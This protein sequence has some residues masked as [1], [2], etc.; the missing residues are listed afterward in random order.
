MTRIK[1]SD[2]MCLLM[3]K[4][5]TCGLSLGGISPL[6]RTLSFLILVAVMTVPV[7]AFAGAARY[8]TPMWSMGNF[9]PHDPTNITA[10][11][12]SPRL[13]FK[14]MSLAELSAKID[15]GYT[16][17]AEMIGSFMGPSLRGKLASFYNRRNYPASG[18]P[19][20][21]FGDFC[22]FDNTSPGYLKAVCVEFTGGEDG[23]YV[24][25]LQSLY[26]ET[27]TIDQQNT[28]F[29]VVS[30]EG[31]VTYKN[32][33][34][35]AVISTEWENGSYGVATLQLAKFVGAGSSALVWPGV[36]V[37]DIKGYDFSGTLGG[38]PAGEGLPCTA[39]NRRIVE[40][41]GVATA[42]TVE[43][44]A[45]SEDTVSCVVLRLTNGD[46]GVLAEAVAARSVS[47]ENLGCV[48][49]NGDG[50]YNGDSQSIATGYDTDGYGLYGLTAT[51]EAIYAVSHDIVTKTAT[52][53]W[54]GTTLDDI[55]NC[56][57]GCRFTGNHI[58]AGNRGFEGRGCNPRI[59]RDANGSATK[60]R[61]EYQV[62]DN[63]YTYIKC[64]LV[65]LTNGAD[66]VYATKVGTG[67]LNTTTEKVGRYFG[68]VSGTAAYD[69]Y[70]L[71]AVPCI[72]LA[73]DEDWSPH[74]RM[75]LGDAV[76]DLNGH[77]LTTGELFFDTCRTG[78]VV[79]TATS[80][81]AQLRT[82]IFE[83]GVIS[84]DC[85]NVGN[86]CI[87]TENIK[88]VK[89]GKGIYLATKPLEYTGGT[90]ITGGVMKGA[91][92]S[93]DSTDPVF[94]DYAGAITVDAG[95][96]LDWNGSWNFC[97]YEFVLDGGTLQNGGN[98]DFG[99]WHGLLKKITL[100][101]DSSFAVPRSWGLINNSLATLTLDLGVNT[102]N[103]N[104]GSGKTI[105]FTNVQVLGTGRIEATGA[106]NFEVRGDMNGIGFVGSAIDL[107]VSCELRIHGPMSVHD[108]EASATKNGSDIGTGVLAV[109][110]TFKP[111][112]QYFRGVTMQD[113]STMD[114]SE[115]PGTFP[116]ATD[117]TCIGEKLI[118]FAAADE[119]E[120]TT[121][122]VKLGEQ[123]VSTSTPIVA[124][125]DDNRPNFSKV[126][127]LRGD[128]DRKY[129]LVNK[130]DGLYVS[131]GLMIIIR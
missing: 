60:M 7:L 42:M 67:Y 50:T 5:R 33:T 130:D 51:K 45:A 13:A 107:H 111:T 29:M 128:S 59:T 37:D 65:D 22:I 61:V 2:V 84:N 74:G 26:K 75:A 31:M 120:V 18:T 36:T 25:A 116:V 117:Y 108:Y 28:D 105:Y 64:T 47:G 15:D 38:R 86:K 83:G 56:W 82:Y 3:R 112:T 35:L 80:T 32:Y 110:G 96:I 113:G 114:F 95:A 115:W 69:V 39:Y 49:S 89:D 81:T 99:V 6:R 34:G 90:E 131:S 21:I 77:S 62:Y 44:Q 30:T 43:M 119:G 127:F 63:N 94:G 109:N 17:F 53:V 57:L 66:G 78:M 27:A 122:T 4:I 14:G 92:H 125:N 118:K 41:G 9:N 19:E 10:V 58:Y 16:I 76:V 48:F 70:D 85:V 129:M 91:K 126:K 124:W 8:A 103:V 72:T 11:T 12:T 73:T 101:R 54:P 97:N 98:V 102:L 93:G 55:T 46:G 71:S 87:S 24:K 1:S 68:D 100:T 104:I 23:V 121:I 20:K 123:N 52:L 79:N 88:F 106:G 40:D